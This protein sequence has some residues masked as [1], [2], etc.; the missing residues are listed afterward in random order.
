MMNKPELPKNSGVSRRNFLKQSSLFSVAAMTSF[1][2][3]WKSI[4]AMADTFPVIDTI[5]GKVRGMDTAGIMT[6]RGIRYGESTAGKNRLG[7]L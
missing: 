1:M 6:F 5:Y 4:A 7:H 3:P 2:L